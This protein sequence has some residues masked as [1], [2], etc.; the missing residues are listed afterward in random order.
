MKQFLNVFNEMMGEKMRSN[1]VSD[2]TIHKLV[3]EFHNMADREQDACLQ[4]L[5]ETL[6]NY[7]LIVYFMSLLLEYVQDRK[8]LHYLQEPLKNQKYS[9]W[10][11]L[12]DLKY[13]HVRLFHYPHLN[14]EAKDYQNFQSVY[15][16]ILDDIRLEM[17]NHYPWIPYEER[18]KRL[19]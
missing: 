11:R 14:D 12:N 3:L 4:F 2:E 15:K 19:C 13:L 5:Y 9:L 17:E 7:D 6:Q 16:R 8:I 1:H 10:D 18:K